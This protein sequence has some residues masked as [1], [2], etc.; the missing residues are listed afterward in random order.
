MAQI[1]DI[2]WQMT[3][4]GNGDDRGTAIIQSADSGFV[5][6]GYSN[7]L[8]GDITS[9]HGNEDFWVAKLDSIGNFQWQ[10][11]YGGSSAD[12]CHAICYGINGGYLLVGQSNSNDG[13]LT[14]NKGGYDIWV[15]KISETGD[16]EW[17][18][19]YGGT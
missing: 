1:I 19:N 14:E 18:N 5:V 15:V 17:Q 8:D 16:I 4:G 12:F 2:K 3:Y 11:S 7:A 9:P 13:D 6:A 10:K